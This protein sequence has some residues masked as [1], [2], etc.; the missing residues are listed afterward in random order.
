MPPGNVWKKFHMAHS[1]IGYQG[2]RKRSAPSFPDCAI[3]QARSLQGMRLR[4][5]LKRL[6]SRNNKIQAEGALAEAAVHT[7]AC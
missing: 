4:P 6:R 3:R 5:A 1:S 7:L 2:N